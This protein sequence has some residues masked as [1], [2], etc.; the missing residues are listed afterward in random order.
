M[1][2]MLNV[3]KHIIPSAPPKAQELLALLLVNTDRDG[4]VFINNLGRREVGQIYHLITRAELWDDKGF[5]TSITSF[6]VMSGINWSSG[7]AYQN[8]LSHTFK[9]LIDAVFD[10]RKTF[11][12]DDGTERPCFGL[13]YVDGR[14]GN[15]RN[16]CSGAQNYPASEL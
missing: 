2:A 6:I 15:D 9:R 5:V 14:Y 4:N 7:N 16:T 3:V 8:R 12:A 10:R 1:T 11:D 13:R